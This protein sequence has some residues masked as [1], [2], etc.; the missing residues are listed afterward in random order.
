MKLLIFDVSIEKSDVTTKN[1]EAKL[2]KLWPE[3]CLSEK[4]K[5]EK[6][7]EKQNE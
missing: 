3:K 4:L 2:I 6:K 5:N 7:F 1:L